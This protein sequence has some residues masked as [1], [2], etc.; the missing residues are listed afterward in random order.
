M[1][2]LLLSPSLL[3]SFFIVLLKFIQLLGY[4]AASVYQK[5]LI[6]RVEFNASLDTV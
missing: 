6:D 2:L 4:P 3:H 5:I 1:L